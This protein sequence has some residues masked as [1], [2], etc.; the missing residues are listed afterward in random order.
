M[1]IRIW[2][3]DLRTPPVGWV[4]VKDS[5][6]AIE[7]LAEFQ[8]LGTDYEVISFDHDL[9]GDDTS[10]RVMMW[11]IENEFFPTSE[12]FVHTANPVGRTWLVGTAERYMPDHVRV[13]I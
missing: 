7:T 2:L 8:K 3:D 4:W 13:R 10:R 6:S 9:G 12:V 11:I 1:T 5:A